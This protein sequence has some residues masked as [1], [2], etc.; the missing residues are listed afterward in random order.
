MELDLKQ[1]KVKYTIKEVI[2]VCSIIL[3]GA[4]HM[5]RTEMEFMSV[6]KDLAE[7]QAE[8]KKYQRDTK[9]GID[10]LKCKYAN[11]GPPCV[12]PQEEK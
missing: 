1:V 9:A 5:I 8:V 6:K 3:T 11:A 12:S 4:A 2:I 10:S 7:C